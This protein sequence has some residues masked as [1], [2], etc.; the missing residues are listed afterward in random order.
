MANDRATLW[1]V[2]INNPTERD[3]EDIA[4]SRQRG[5]K[6]EGQKEVGSEGTPHYQLAVKTPQVRFAALKKAFPRAHI[7]CARNAPALQTYVT[8]EATR[9]GSLPTTQDKYPSLSKL[10]DLIYAY[11]NASDWKKVVRSHGQL[12]IE[13]RINK[14]DIFDDAIKHLIENGYHVETHGVNPQVRSAWKMYSHALFQRSS[15]TDR[16]TDTAL[17]TTVSVPTIEHNHAYEDERTQ[18]GLS[19]A[20]GSWTGEDSED[21]QEYSCTSDEGCTEGTGDESGEDSDC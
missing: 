13:A 16:Q 2:T 19:E 21:Y 10:W 11:I 5:W 4:R 15:Q 20:S 1:S 8:K 12:Y 17:E 3:E 7:E 18:G 14:L 6:V 9:V